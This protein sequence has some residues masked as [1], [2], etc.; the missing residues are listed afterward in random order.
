MFKCLTR[1][2]D[3]VSKPQ[4]YK[5]TNRKYKEESLIAEGGFAYIWRCENFAI[6]RILI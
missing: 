5:L 1:K 3:P 6:K 2:T 4:S